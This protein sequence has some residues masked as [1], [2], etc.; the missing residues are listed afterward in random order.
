MTGRTKGRLAV[1]GLV[2]VVLVFGVALARTERARVRFWTWR[3]HAGGL[4]ASDA[5]LA[6][7]RI[8]RP[9]I[10]DVYPEI[11]ADAVSIFAARE[12]VVV[13]GV[14]TD[15]DEFRRIRL[16]PSD[17]FGKMNDI[18]NAILFF[19]QEP[20]DADP[21]LG[22]LRGMPGK[23]RIVVASYGAVAVKLDAPVDQEVEERVVE[24][25]RARL[26]MPHVH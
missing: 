18:P 9:A 25:V 26:T 13:F 21:M 5:R 8:G 16:E 23:R 20:R 11:V 17:V 14:A 19:G 1:L 3:L 12:D 22:L 7:L 24:A 10:D 15:T 4:E 6:L 2:L